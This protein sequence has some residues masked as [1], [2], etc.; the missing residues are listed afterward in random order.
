MRAQANADDYAFLCSGVSA[1]EVLAAV[2]AVAP[3]GIQLAASG[4]MWG[5]AGAEALPLVLSTV[6]RLISLK[7]EQCKLG[8]AGATA[9]APALS[10]MTQLTTMYIDVPPVYIDVHRC[11]TRVHRYT[12][13]YHPCTSMYHDV[14]PLYIDVP[15]SYI[16]VLRCTADTA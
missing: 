11:T 14:P 1:R 5:D 15:P 10:K 3:L 12:S 7:L 6:T 13:M 16:D 8:A 2:K 4:N 9:F